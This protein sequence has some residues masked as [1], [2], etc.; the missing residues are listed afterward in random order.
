MRLE[1]LHFPADAVCAG[2]ACAILALDAR[3]TNIKLAEVNWILV[4]YSITIVT[5]GLCTFLIVHR[6]V[7]VGGWA[8]SLKTYRGIIELLV[9]SALAYS[10]I[11]LVLV[12]LYGLDLYSGKWYK[13]SY[14]YPWTLVNSITVSVYLSLQR[15]SF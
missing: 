5:N 11:Y 4:H 1:S 6:I 8:K 3:L 15:L 7:S 12:I 9:E 10:I 13:L 14:R 2:S